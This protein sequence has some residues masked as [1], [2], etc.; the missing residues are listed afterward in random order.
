MKKKRFPIYYCRCCRK[1]KCRD[2]TKSLF[3]D[4]QC[5]CKYCDFN[6][7]GIITIIPKIFYVINWCKLQ[8]VYK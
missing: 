3:D 8:K 4:M 5:L 2:K 7:L 6:G 1:C